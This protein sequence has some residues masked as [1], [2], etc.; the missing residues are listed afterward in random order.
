MLLLVTLSEPFKFEC[1]E[2]EATM[3]YLQWYKC[4]KSTL[5]ENDKPFNQLNSPNHTFTM[6]PS[7]SPIIQALARA[8]AAARLRAQR[9]ES[10]TPDEP[11]IMSDAPI[12]SDPAN[13]GNAGEDA[14]A[15]AD[16]ST[17]AQQEPS[18]STSE[19]H[20]QHVLTR[21]QRYKVV[22]WMAQ[23]SAADTPKKIPSQAVAHFPEY[24][25]GNR[26]A[27]LQR[28]M[29]YW[30]QRDSIISAYKPN[31]VRGNDL[32]HATPTLAGV[33]V[34]ISKAAKGRGRK[35]AEWVSALYCD[36]KSEFE[37]LCKLGVK[38]NMGLLKQLSLRLVSLD[39]NDK[40][41]NQTTDPKSERLISTHITSRWI[42]AFMQNN[43]IVCR[44][45]VGKLSICS[46]KQEMIEREVA[47]HLGQMKR[48]FSNGNL[49]EEDV[50]NADETHFKIDQN[51]GHTL[52]GHEMTDSVKNA[53]K[54]SNTVLRYLP[55]NAT[56]LCQPA[57]S[58]VIQKIKTAWRAKWDKRRMESVEKAEWTNWKSGS[59]KLPNPGKPFFLKLAAEVIREVGVMRDSEGMLYTRKAMMRCGLSCNWNGRWEEDQLFPHL[60]VIVRKYRENFEG[61]SV[62]ESMN[63]DGEATVSGED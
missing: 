11:A 43:N 52:T 41:N 46:A 30:N 55:K 39:E 58:F 35:R 8:N 20:V 61:K 33:H 19:R 54:E 9:A 18:A 3:H 4:L 22:Q 49:K 53:L 44:A 28:A 60:Q 48:D 57:D 5:G 63:L 50:Y 7:A 31:G 2:T 16:E 27:N 10:E 47:V 56:E 36:L 17:H 59:G 15:A 62:E 24:F 29:R 25:R 21:P 23:K 12:P 42:Q 32:Y 14:G 45:Q 40:C 1:I 13:S 37:R 6:P 26:N 38:F 34:R 51:D